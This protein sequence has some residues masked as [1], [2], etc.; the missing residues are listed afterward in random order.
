MSFLHPALLWLVP[1]AAIPIILHLLTLHR[2]KTVELSTYRFL[3]DSYIQQRRQMRFLE[4]LLAMLRTLFLLAMVFVVGRPVV[5][6][7]NELFRS[8]SG[9]DVVLLLDCSASMN[10]VTQGKTA[11]T[12]AKDAAQ[13]VIDRLHP[14]DRVT[15]IRV[16][17]KPEEVFSK[18]SSDVGAIRE[19]LEAQ[20]T[21][22]SRANVFAALMHVFGSSDVPRGARLVYFFTDCQAS[23]WKEI[24][25]QGLERFIPA[26]TEFIVANTGSSEPIPNLAVIGDAPRRQRAIVG[27]PI[28]L[29]ARVANYS[30]DKAEATVSVLIDDKDIA[31]AS[32]TMKPGEIVTRKILYTPAEPGVHRGR[33][34]ITGK[35][36]DRF[37]DDD[38]FLFTLTV[39]PRLKVLLINGRPSADPL[40]S[41]TLYLHTALTSPNEA[42]KSSVD[43]KKPTQ[44]TKELPTGLT[45]GALD[46]QEMPEASLNPAVLQEAGVVV[47]ANCGR[48]NPQQF[49]WLRDFVAAG[50]GLIILPGDQV[51]PDIYN[52]QFFP[53]PGPQKERLIGV[54]FGKPD[55]D[56]DKTESYERLNPD[57]GH[58]VL[59]VFEDPTA[60]YFR[61][62]YVKRRLPLNPAG[63]VKKDKDTRTLPANSFALAEFASGTLALV[64]GRYGEGMVIVS[65]FPAHPKWTNLP[66]KAGEFVPLM[67]RLVSYAAR[68]PEVETPAVVPPDG[69]AEVLVTA[70]WDP[71]TG[72]VTEP[73]GKSYPLELERSGLRLAGAFDRTSEAGYY[74]VSVRSGRAEAPKNEVAAFAVNL[75]PEESEFTRV[76]EEQLR[77]LLPSAQLTLVDASAE[78]QQLHGNIGNE[79]EIWRPLIWLMFIIIGAEFTLATLGGQRVETGETPTVAE[80]IL[81]VRAGGLFGG[82]GKKEA[83][84]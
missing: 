10:A 50:G 43:A 78:A 17:G 16:T 61:Q 32:L 15:L 29:Q 24:R 3:F 52:Q 45:A 76:N 34:E 83:K 67:L 79:R 59:T 4:A 74:S 8:G 77:E 41:E 64:E 66:L 58:P 38:R 75:S 65:A 42:K 27:L 36:H 70:S 39:A 11:F 84:G 53:V 9:R 23:G 69:S 47:L 37:P 31:R 44:A 49:I 5:R 73:G 81:Q 48:L 60:G 63:Q 13:S 21:S 46:V 28:V 22:P 20:K 51:N 72:K 82:L 57:F 54:E 25:S 18:F 80:R 68:R 40:E 71:A 6:H 56:P 55:G 30:A 12:R 19:K 35:T 7:W 26:E 14:D 1:L 62:V 2:L 33:F